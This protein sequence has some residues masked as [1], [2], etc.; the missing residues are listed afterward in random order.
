METFDIYL[1]T[2]G[3]TSTTHSI[4]FVDFLF[5]RLIMTSPSPIHRVNRR[6][7]L[8]ATAAG[9]LA[10]LTACASDIRPLA[11]GSARLTL[12]PVLPV[13]PRALQLVLTQCP[14]LALRL[15]LLPASIIRAS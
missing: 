1:H 5:E 11:D 3:M 7:A 12:L 2:L 9:A 8:G 15:L 4:S 6:V 13:H 10:A 14:R